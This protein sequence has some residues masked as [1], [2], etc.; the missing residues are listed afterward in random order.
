MLIV[1]SI[2]ESMTSRRL[3]QTKTPVK[4]GQAAASHQ[5]QARPFVVQQPSTSPQPQD[6]QIQQRQAQRLDQGLINN[7]SIASARLP[8]PST[9]LQKKG[10]G[11]SVSPASGTPISRLGDQAIQRKEFGR[12]IRLKSL[13]GTPSRAI[14]LGPYSDQ[15]IAEELYGDAALPVTHAPGDYSV[16][17]IDNS[18]LLEHWQPLFLNEDKAD[19]ATEQAPRPVAND[20]EFS[21]LEKQWIGE[22][23]HDPVISLV[24]G[25]YALPEPVLSRVRQIPGSSTTKGQFSSQ[26]D[27]IKLADRIYSQKEEHSLAG[28]RFEETDEEAFKGTLIHEIF[29]YLEDNAERTTAEMPIPQDLIS[30]MIAP[31]RVGLPEYAFGWFVHPHSGWWL[32]FQL[33]EVTNILASK[34]VSIQEHPDLLKVSREKK[35]E[36]SPLPRSGKSISIEEDLCESFSLA[37]ASPRTREVLKTKYPMRYQLLDHYIRRLEKLNKQAE[38][39]D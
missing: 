27:G 13:D 15:A 25:S 3:A 24:F 37:L 23:T 30:A 8:S 10:L 17:L 14:V 28:E 33:P 36:N 32:H 11:E 18:R 20:K 34:E 12:S 29:H 22:V 5:V 16:I 7:L 21:P 26:T 31:T 35:W 9:S 38:R 39:T 19:E 2:N 1:G 6:L 4:S